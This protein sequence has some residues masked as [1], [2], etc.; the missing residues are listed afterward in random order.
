MKWVGFMVLL[1]WGLSAYSQENEV[2]FEQIDSL[3][4]QISHVKNK[5]D[6]AKELELLFERFILNTKTLNHNQSYV[7]G[8]ELEA[9][10]EENK[11]LDIVQK[12]RQ[13]FYSRM[14]WLFNTFGEYEMSI[15]Y[16]QKSIDLAEETGNYESKYKDLGAVAFTHY[17]LG[18]NE[19]AE[20]LL[21]QLMQEVTDLGNQE[22]IAEIQ[23]RYYTVWIDREPEKALGHARA[24]LNTPN[25]R[26]YTHRLLCVGTCFDRLGAYDSALF[27]AN[28]GLEIAQ[29]KDFFTQKSNGHILLKNIYSGMG[30]FQKAL[31]NF[32]IYHSLHIN[33]KSFRSGMML[34]AINQKILEEKLELQESLAQEKLSNQ[35]SLMWIFVIS[36]L[37]LG[38]ILFILYSR[39]KLINHQKKRIEEEKN[40]AEQSERYVEQFLTNISH[41]IRTP[42][43]AIS[44]MVNALLRNPDSEFK[45]EY[46]EVMRISSDN[47]LVLLND[48]LDLAKIESGKIQIISEE[49]KPLQVATGVV[50]LLKFKASEKGLDL[51]IDVSEDF[52]ETMVSDPARLTQVLINLI[53]N[54]IKFTDK[55]QIRLRLSRENDWA[56]FEIV[57]SGMGIPAE[58]LQVIFDSFEQVDQVRTREYGGTGLGLSISKKLIE[59]QGGRI[60]AESELGKG[61][62]FIFE[63]PIHSSLAEASNPNL[64]PHVDLKTLGEELAGIRILLVDDDEFN[65]M[66]VQDDLNYFIPELTITVAKNG[67]EALQLFEKEDFDLIFMDIHMP[68]MGGIAAAEKIRVL[69]AQNNAKKRIPI[70]ALTANIVQ[71]EI[72]KFMASG[73]DDYIPKPYK[74]EEILLKMHHFYKQELGN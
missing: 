35:R 62:T 58:K 22:L 44:G 45:Q 49:I 23:Y 63:L 72:N 26:D 57:D 29:E 16:Y 25:Q 51:G 6:L 27:Y 53:G 71:S 41:E 13:P 17:L 7:W 12:I 66:V 38:V 14:G 74:V 5:D 11:S 54:A 50:N 60:W 32:E 34:M 9:L 69:E 31:E 21:D 43:H 64:K 20:S 68:G 46:L 56:R 28:K 19:E 24:S 47:L 61:S 30:D 42:M 73:M 48:M 40:R 4:E 2:S 33:S 10:I 15:E 1:L 18:R 39:I 67:E 70:I 65:M 59:L 8:L 55:G 52:P 3:T 37:V 36:T